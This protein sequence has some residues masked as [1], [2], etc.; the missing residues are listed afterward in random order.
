[1]VRRTLWLGV[2]VVL[3]ALW[4]VPVLAAQDTPGVVPGATPGAEVTVLGQIVNRTPGGSV[5]P[6]LPVMIHA[7]DANGQEQLARP[8]EA[9]ADGRIRFENVPVVEGWTYAL[10]TTYLDVTYF[11]EPF[12]LTG[13]DRPAV[14]EVPIYDQTS[15]TSSVVIE[16]FHVFFDVTTDGVEV[17]E[18]YIVSN[19][20]DRT[21]VGAVTLSDGSQATLLF[22]LP[23]GA[24]NV[25]FGP[26]LD[27]V[28]LR[29]PGGFA[30]PRPVVPG[31]GSHQV[32]VSYTLPWRS[33]WTY[34]H[35]ARYPIRGVTAVVPSTSGLALEEE[36][37]IFAGQRTSSDG[38]SL[39]VY[40]REGLSPGG[41]LTVTLRGTP[42]LRVGS[43]VGREDVR[44]RAFPWDVVVGAGVLVATLLGVG[45][46]WQRRG[47]RGSQTVPE[48]ATEAFERVIAAMA[49]LDE[50]YERGEVTPA[51]YQEQRDR[52]RRQARA[53]LQQRLSSGGP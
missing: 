49:A 44:S 34:R 30:D 11:S 41:A 24:A 21:V 48:D 36:G 28:L 16:R 42:N 14:V 2:L 33:E 38:L 46:W 50:A 6:A 52:L 12:R 4:G 23:P 20:G 17:T 7:W 47:G 9:T 43:M 15:D 29:Q 19:V 22:P 53:L 10:M 13:G 40:T 35:E 1:M 25:R 27:N 32:F 5:P 3:W 8:G 18:V 45:L 31:R 37:L 51:A 26:M 39:D